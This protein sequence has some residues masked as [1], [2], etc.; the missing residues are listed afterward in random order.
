MVQAFPFA[1]VMNTDDSDE[2]IPS[3]HHREAFN[4]QFKG[5]QPNMRAENIPGTREK[6]NP[7]LIND[8]N[9]LTIGRHYDAVNKRIF[10]FNY[11]GDN[12][13]GI[14]MY[15]T[16]AG[17]FYR[18]VEQG[19]NAE[20]DVL[21]FTESV[22][23]NID[24]I[25]GDSSQGDI[26]YFVDGNHVPK[27]IN[28]NRA[29][30]G[31]YGTIKKSFLEV[32]K[33]PANIPPFVVYEDDASSTV[34]NL[35]KKLFK[36]KIRWVF[37]DRDKAVTSTQSE[38]PLPYQAFNQAIDSDATKNCRIAI[39]YQTGPSNVK[40][41]E[42]LAT[43]SLGVTFSDYFLIA[44]IDK[45]AEGVASNDINT[46]LFYNDKGYSNIDV[47]ESD[48]IQ[49]YVPQETVAQCVL[50]G[51]VLSYGN[52]IE[53]YPNLTDFS[54]GSNTSNITSSVVVESTGTFFSLFEVAQG[55]TKAGVVNGTFHLVVRGNV[56]QN[57]IYTAYIEEGASVTT[58]TYTALPGDDAAAVIEGLRVD[59]ISKGYTVVS[60]DSNNLYVTKSG[61]LLSRFILTQSTT[62]NTLQESLNAYDWFS[63]YSFGL[64]YFDQKG[65]TNQV[66]YT[67]GFSVSSQ[68]Y[69]QSNSPCDI[70]KFTANIYHRP[71]DW[72]YYFQ[73]VRTKDL[74]K[75]STQQW[76]SDRTFKDDVA[77]NGIVKYAYISIESLNAFVAANIGSPLGYS[78]TAGDRV[79]FIKLYNADGSTNQI[80]S[81]KDFEITSS[82][83]N[84]TINGEVKTGQFI[85]IVLPTT[86]GSFDFGGGDFS[87]YFI[88]LYTPA[89]SVAN[90]LNVY[91]EFGEMYM[92]AFPTEATR[93]HQGMI[94]NQTNDLVSPAIFEFTKGDYYIRNRSVQT[95]NVFLWNVAAGS[96]TVDRCL[97]G[98]NFVSQTYSDSNFTAH[99]V[100][101]AGISGS[102]NPNTDGR[103]F[104]SLVNGA[105]VK[106]EGS[107][108]ITFPTAKAGDFWQIFIQLKDGELRYLVNPFDAS[109]AGTYTFA[110]NTSFPIDHDNIFLQASSVGSGSRAISFQ[111]SSITL[112]VDHVISQ[113]MIDRNFSDYFPS[114]VNSNGRAF[115]FD[116]NANRVNYPTL[117][118][119][120][121][122]YQTDTNI[123]KTNRFYFDN[124]DTLLRDFG[125]IRRMMKWDKELTIFQERKVGRVGVFNKFITDTSGSQQLITST[126]I[127]TPNNV[128]YYA[129]DYGVGLQGDSVVQSGFV[130]YFTDPIKGKQLRLSR[131]GIIDLSELY[132]TQTWAASNISKYL[133]T[134]NYTF[135]GI[136]RITGTFNIRK[137]NTG[138]Y[139]CVLQPGTL[140]DDSIP[141]QTIAFDERRNAFTSF[142]NYA[143]EC[144]ICAEN[145]LYSWVNG[146][147]YIHDVTSGNGMN[148]FYGTYYDSTITKVF[149][150]AL[151]EKK[152]WMSL[153]EISNV[154]WDCP[155]IYTNY[156]S[157]GNE[158]QESNLITQDFYDIESTFSASFLGDLHSI[159][160]LYGD[161]LKGNLIVIKFRAQN[162]TSLVFL[163]AI[164]LYFIDS[165]FTNR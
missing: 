18:I 28:I 44:S 112:T 72:A 11:R 164:N 22:I 149:N 35:R 33:E 156:M 17:L 7:F 30:S 9:N 27:K 21:A 31:G 5:T 8:G 86:S 113:V 116:E 146:K 124:S 46:Y 104:F 29:L 126:G 70:T 121:L 131:D 139:L 103:W 37:D 122:A 49:D 59:A 3:I 81:N 67:N 13:K 107:I 130:Y 6:T 134:Y 41:I 120:S 32:A 133:N 10:F 80:Y 109:A 163:S 118:R 69:S 84:P 12:S 132:K 141:A 1:G 158:R 87:N 89:Q 110:L 82:V 83:T 14:Y 79:R 153:T 136:S 143:P 51:N 137:D 111:A 66:V 23:S 62:A 43:L 56:F 138:E 2:V 85:K 127:I 16:I 19:V 94:Q 92:I 15:D 95:G 58:I 52:I 91:Y 96:G 162:A 125:S 47:V 25:Y 73:W 71:P 115:I 114:A 97:I 57:N 147:M 42:I 123:N 101:L 152:S 74:S 68:P 142:Y 34:N 64:V 45:D 99:S 108:S 50:N 157:Y 140:G 128:Q 76:I 39:V 106:I 38:V 54:N 151:I 155:L 119:Y 154:I 78:F 63:K 90:G 88:E 77:I 20:N 135:G 102:F 93:F 159:G 61:A 36:F 100:T 53:G 98:L 165:P 65:R 105:T 26:L 161:V 40:K 148:K 145:T 24:I 117:Y 60:V 129:G 55:G 160:G 150:S 4:V 144:I 48:Q 75:S